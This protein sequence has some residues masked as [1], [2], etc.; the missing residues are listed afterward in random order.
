MVKM[1]PLLRNDPSTYEMLDYDLSMAPIG[2]QLCGSNPKLAA[3]AS[4]IIEE[5][6]FHLIDLNCGCPVDK[7]TKD[8][9][10][11]GLLKNPEKIGEIISNMVA[12]VKIPVTL[13]IRTGWDEKNINAKEIT[14]IAE[15][16]GAQIITIHGRTREQKYTGTANW[17]HIK[18]CKEIAKKI[19]VF[20]NGDVFDASHAIALFSHT[21]CDGVLVSRGT[22]GQ[23]WIAQEIKRLDQEEPPLPLSGFE[24]RD[25]LLKHMSFIV[26][27][28][29]ERLAILDMRRV[30]CW[31]LRKGEGTKKLRHSINTCNDLKE[32]EALIKGYDWNCLNG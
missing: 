28:R 10:G 2:A 17:D 29:Q 24:M 19:K 12:A 5:L 8:G 16:A 25:L 21:N 30:G 27:Y 15:K 3:P 20:G 31:Y 9:S 7:V 4:K 23:P 6:G 14:Q 18:E 22:L 11:S 13:K 1:E 26:S 32:I